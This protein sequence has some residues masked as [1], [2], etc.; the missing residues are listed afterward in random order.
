LP[1]AGILIPW[2]ITNN[3]MGTLTGTLETTLKAGVNLS[4]EGEVGFTWTDGDIDFIS[5]MPR[6]SALTP[7]MELPSIATKVAFDYGP[8]FAFNLCGISLMSVKETGG[9]EFDTPL[10]GLSKN[11]L[12]LKFKSSCTID[13]LKVFA[14][15]LEKFKNNIGKVKYTFTPFS[16]GFQIWPTQE[17]PAPNPAPTPATGSMSRTRRGTARTRPSSQ[18]RPMPSLPAWQRSSTAP[19]RCTTF[20]T[21]KPYASCP[22]STSPDGNGRRS[23]TSQARSTA[24]GIR[25]RT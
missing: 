22:T 15:G 12:D 19:A 13:L 6:S 1:I 23:P 20:S 4:L 5:P 10:S 7:V 8:N 17:Q 24:A 25:Y 3:E 14:K 21:T 11:H 2:T 18:S 16:F 9:L